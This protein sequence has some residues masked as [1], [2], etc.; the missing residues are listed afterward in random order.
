MDRDHLEIHLSLIYSTDLVWENS[1]LY[2]DLLQEINIRS[3]FN[4][5]I[6]I[7]SSVKCSIWK[8]SFILFIFYVIL[9][10]NM[11][12]VDLSLSLSLALSHRNKFRM[13]NINTASFHWVVAAHTLNHHSV[14]DSFF[15]FILFF[16][17]FMLMMKLR[18]S[19]FPSPLPFYLPLS[20]PGYSKP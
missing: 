9:F 14:L 13:L 7:Y 19:S 12:I 15:Y 10:K 11:H 20:K 18:S 4:V 1:L 16:C 17:R 2:F 5:C 6:Q 8:Q 3:F